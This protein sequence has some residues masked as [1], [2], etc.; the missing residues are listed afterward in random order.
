[1]WPATPPTTAP[2]IQ[3]LASAA[4]D[5]PKPKASEHARTAPVNFVPMRSPSRSAARWSAARIRF[6][7]YMGRGRGSAT[8][9]S[10]AALTLLCGTAT[11]GRA[12]FRDF[13]GADRQSRNKAGDQQQ[14]G[15]SIARARK[16]AA[17]D[18][19]GQDLG[20]G[21]RPDHAR[22]A[23]QTG[24]GALQGPLLRYAGQP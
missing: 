9:R 22:N 10:A 4:P 12:F 21:D 23:T 19:V 5:R 8:A 24:E 16:M 17:V 6:T 3:P 20:E 1:M 11:S 18:L 14:G 7:A 13:A 15:Q 2:L